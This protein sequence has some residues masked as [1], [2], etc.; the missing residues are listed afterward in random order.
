MHENL[1]LSIKI[2][3][4]D[5]EAIFPIYY[6]I[7]EIILHKKLLTTASANHG[8]KSHLICSVVAPFVL[9]SRPHPEIKPRIGP[10]I[11]LLTSQGGDMDPFTPMVSPST[12]RRKLVS[13][14]HGGEGV[15]LW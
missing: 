4:G 13:V 14:S 9:P 15:S 1:N 12:S 8:I 11:P 10:A 7:F 2:R 5:A 3:V 6:L